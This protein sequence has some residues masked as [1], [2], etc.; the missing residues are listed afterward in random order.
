MNSSLPTLLV[1]Y[2][3]HTSSVHGPL[4]FLF[5]PKNVEVPR[6]SATRRNFVKPPRAQ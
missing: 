6:G 3:S 1:F 4:L 5:T 2:S